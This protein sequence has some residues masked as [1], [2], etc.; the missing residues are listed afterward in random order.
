M[1][2]NLRWTLLQEE[3]NTVEVHCSSCGI[4]W[5]LGP[6]SA[7][8]KRVSPMLWCYHSNI[9]TKKQACTCGTFRSIGQFQLNDM[10]LPL[11]IYTLSCEENTSARA[12]RGVPFFSRRVGMC[13]LTLLLLLLIC[14]YVS[15]AVSGWT[16]RDWKTLEETKALNSRRNLLRIVSI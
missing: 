13:S 7:T 5:R 12:V 4:D 8:K 16:R 1:R 2:H 15:C 11:L 9:K 3:Q 6:W 10:L 14:F